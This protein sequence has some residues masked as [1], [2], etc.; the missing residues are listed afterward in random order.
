MS[1]P[2]NGYQ[3]V[4]NIDWSNPLNTYIVTL[5]GQPLSWATATLDIINDNTVTL[6]A[7]DGSILSGNIEFN[8]DLPSI[9][10]PKTSEFSCWNQLLSNISRI[11]VINM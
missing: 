10:W 11:H 5:T 8:G 2:D 3:Y 1:I 6:T 7:D 4:F 9:C